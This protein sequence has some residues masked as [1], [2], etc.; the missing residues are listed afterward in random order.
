MRPTVKGKSQDHNFEVCPPAPPR[1]NVFS[2]KL[3]AFFPQILLMQLFSSCCS[4]SPLLSG[5]QKLVT[6]D[7]DAGNVK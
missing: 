1:A 5:C 4:S 7:K 3:F 6:V 2:S